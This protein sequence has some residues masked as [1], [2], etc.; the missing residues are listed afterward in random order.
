MKN[1]ADLGSCYP[2]RPSA[3]VDN[4]LLDL[5]NSSYLTQPH[6]L[7]AEYNY[8]HKNEKWQIRRS[9]LVH[10]RSRLFYSN[11]IAGILYFSVHQI[12]EISGPDNKKMPPTHLCCFVSVVIGAQMINDEMPLKINI[13]YNIIT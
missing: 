10:C 3:S 12:P 5:L 7:I 6:S 11:T 1:Q 9:A 4:T 2:P 8:P 13:R